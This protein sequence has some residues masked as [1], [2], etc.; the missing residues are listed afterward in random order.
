MPNRFSQDADFL[1]SCLRVYSTEERAGRPVPSRR[2]PT[3][4]VCHICGRKAHRRNLCQS[5]I[6]REKKYGD[7]TIR[8][9]GERGQGRQP[10]AR[11]KG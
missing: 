6:V 2:E 10:K 4:K 1:I 5:C 3:P 8:M 9:R 11:V 7:P